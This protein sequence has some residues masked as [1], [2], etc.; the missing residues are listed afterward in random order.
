[1]GC[2]SWW[3]LVVAL[4][5]QQGFCGQ[6]LNFFVC[7]CCWVVL[8]AAAI[9]TPNEAGFPI[10]RTACTSSFRVFCSVTVLTTITFASH[11]PAG[12]LHRSDVLESQSPERLSASQLP[13]CTGQASAS[14]INNSSSTATRPLC[15]ANAAAPVT[16]A[17]GLGAPW[18]AAGVLLAG[19]A[20]S[21]TFLSRAAAAQWRSS[22][23]GPQ[24]WSRRCSQQTASCQCTT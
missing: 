18:A 16:H 3:H 5:A 23:G 22:R 12:P 14:I 13:L 8:P 6:F 19:G 15:P 24:R 20:S 11:S 7:V 21:S 17:A 4:L 2:Y 10:S 9:H 1:M